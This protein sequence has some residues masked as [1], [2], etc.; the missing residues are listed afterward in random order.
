MYQIKYFLKAG[1]HSFVLTNPFKS[2]KDSYA[3]QYIEMGKELKKATKKYADKN[4]CEEKPI[5]Y[6]IC[7]WGLNKPWLWGRQAGNL[8][9]TTP[10][11][12][13]IWASVLGIY[14]FNVRLNKYASSGSFNDPDMLEVG[15]GKLT[16]DENIS[17][18][19][20]WCMMNA[21]LILGNDIRSM[22]DSVLEIVTKKELVRN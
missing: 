21:P 22:P 3:Y 4:N 14:E 9:R 1:E 11:I 12:K 2:E 17:H 19:T 15:N 7:E 10:D 16:Y 5:V 8:W 13:P 20:L 6:S 18:F